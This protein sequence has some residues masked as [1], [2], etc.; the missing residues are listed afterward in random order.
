MNVATIRKYSA[1]L[2]PAISYTL[3]YRFNILMWST[4]ALFVFLATAWMWLSVYSGRSGGGYDVSSIFTYV[5]VAA[6]IGDFVAEDDQDT[7]AEDIV[8]GRLSAYLT[9]PISY[10]W[11][12]SVMM[13]PVRG[14]VLL[15]IP[16]KLLVFLALFP[17]VPTSFPSNPGQWALFVLSVILA[18]CMFVAIDFLNGAFAFWFHRAY[19][20]R[21]LVTILWALC[22]GAYLPI[23]LLPGWI[24]AMILL[25]PFPYLIYAPIAQL[26]GPESATTRLLLVGAQIIWL[27]VLYLAVRKVWS[28]GIKRYEA[29]GA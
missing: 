12:H 26:V 4:R 8:G 23:G 29:V 7:M 17:N 20:I 16:L 28:V 6:M 22:S 19:G 11:R 24:H 25:T 18:T 10:F 2:P 13:I 14:L 5:V 27:V 3:A 1:F 9:Q 15:L 21:W